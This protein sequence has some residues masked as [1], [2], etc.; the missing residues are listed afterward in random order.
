MERDLLVAGAVVVA[1]LIG[2][3]AL[4]VGSIA[5]GLWWAGVGFWG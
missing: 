4:V 5:V 2:S 1:T 3:L